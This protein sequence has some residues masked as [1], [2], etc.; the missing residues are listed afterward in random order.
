MNGRVL[1]TDGEQRAALAIT[2][3]LGRAGY[4][5]TVGANAARSLAG[6]S[7]HCVERVVLPDPLAAP[8]DHGARIVEVARHR[9]M[10][11]VIPVTEAS[12]LALLPLRG[13]LGATRLP[14]PSEESFRR[15][16]DKAALM[17]LAEEQG[18]S[19][20]RSLVLSTASEADLLLEGRITFPVV[21]K[22]TRSLQ[23]R[24]GR[25]FKDGPRYVDRPEM[26]SAA[27]AE[28]PEDAFPLL[29]QERIIGQG[30]GFFFLRWNSRTLARF[31]HRRLREKPPSGGIS[32][33]CESIAADSPLMERAEALLAAEDWQGVAMVEF[34]RDIR[35]G[36]AYLMEVNGRFWGS[37]QLAIDAGVDFPAMLVA[38]ALG[39][40][41]SRV[42]DYRVGVRSRWVMGEL[43]H[44]LIRLRSSNSKLKLPAGA[45]GRLRT[46]ADILLPWR[47]P[48]RGEIWRRDDP[49]PARVEVLDWLKHLV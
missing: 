45:P 18:L 35:D 1:V 4:A 46:A 23:E 48:G 47:S 15:L 16:S 41:A 39:R 20:P 25:R 44:L 40:P 12:L 29:A 31:A 3:S 21:L 5:V 11:V 36:I 2:R 6:A 24:N 9:S 26:L 7:R 38:A 33:Y 37:L 34:K 8:S 42:P 43:D 13:A 49:R 27:L 28:V 10:D 19:T 32:V 22:P 14:F 17:A 30:I